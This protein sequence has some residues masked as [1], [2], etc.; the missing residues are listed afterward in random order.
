[1][2]TRHVGS[3]HV[4][5]RHVTSCHVTCAATPRTSHTVLLMGWYSSFVMCE[6]MRAVTNL[7]KRNP[8]THDMARGWRCVCVRHD[9]T[10]KTSW[11]L[12]WPVNDTVC[13]SDMTRSCMWDV[14]H[15]CLR[16]D[17]LVCV[18]TLIHVCN[19]MN[20][21]VWHDSFM[22][23]AS[24]KHVSDLNHSCVCRHESCMCVTWLIHVYDMTH[25]R[26]SHYSFMCVTCLIYVCAMTH[27]CVCHDLF[28]Y[29]PWLIRVCALNMTHSCMR[30]D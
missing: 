16:H 4:T 11:P 6:T 15:W 29:V 27:S 19:V 7:Q 28:M 1:M 17:S 22:C 30:H 10:C 14:S 21:R 5:S 26:V 12:T 2:C 9:M 23:V 25:S 13:V 8:M 3:R 20:S 18:T 24:I